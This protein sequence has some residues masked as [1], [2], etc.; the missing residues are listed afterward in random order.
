MANIQYAGQNQVMN[1]AGPGSGSAGG[2]GGRQFFESLSQ[3]IRNQF[4]FYTL[5]VKNSG[6]AGALTFSLFAPKD[7][8]TD[9]RV[10]GEVDRAFPSKGGVTDALSTTK[11]SPGSIDELQYIVQHNPIFV[12]YFK[13]KTTG[14]PEAQFANSVI[15]RRVNPFVSYDPQDEIQ[16]DLY[17]NPEQDNSNILYV[18]QA[19]DGNDQTFLEFT[20]EQ[21]TELI[22]QFPIAAVKNDAASLSSMVDRIASGE[23]EFQT[24]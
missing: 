21:G 13:L 11:Q 10:T 16:V 2:V 23:A 14:D 7:L 17:E 6:S 3:S 24:L 5:G 20:V 9:G 4:T 18:N 15:E 12:P 8:F 19:F 22:I 1:A